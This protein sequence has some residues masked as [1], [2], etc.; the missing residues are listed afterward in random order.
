MAGKCQ[1]SIFCSCNSNEKRAVFFASQCDEDVGCRQNFRG[2]VGFCHLGR[3]RRRSPFRCPCVV[4]ERSFGSILQPLPFPFP[5]RSPSSLLLP[6][7]LFSVPRACFLGGRRGLEWTREN[8]ERMSR[9]G[10]P[11]KKAGNEPSEESSESMQWNRRLTSL[12]CFVASLLRSL[13]ELVSLVA[14]TTLR[15]IVRTQVARDPPFLP[16]HVVVFRGSDGIFAFSACLFP[17][18]S[19]PFFWERVTAF[20]QFADEVR[21]R[22]GYT[23]SK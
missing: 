21:V 14:S 9:M 6:L 10:P 8:G 5:P 23:C 12:R 2:S 4:R 15:L 7:S 11:R 19:R 16:S 13:A 3:F 1:D 20:L 17:F 18:C 22:R